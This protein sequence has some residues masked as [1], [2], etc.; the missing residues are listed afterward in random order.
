MIT[1]STIAKK[2]VV[3]SL[4]QSEYSFPE[5]VREDERKK[6]LI[7]GMYTYGSMQTYSYTGYPTDSRGDN[8]D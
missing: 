6:P 8:W 3:Q 5:Q 7:A 1:P 4:P 2:V